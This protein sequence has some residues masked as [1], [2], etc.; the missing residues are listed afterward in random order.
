MSTEL[1]RRA[2]A[3]RLCSN[4]QNSKGRDQDLKSLIQALE[5]QTLEIESLLKQ[6]SILSQALDPNGNLIPF[7]PRPFKTPSPSKMKV[8]DRR[9]C[10]K[11]PCL[12]EGQS[13]EER[14]KLAFEIHTRSQNHIFI[15]SDSLGKNWNGAVDGLDSCTVFLPEV[16]YLN[17][18][19]QNLLNMSLQSE[20]GPL[21]V[22]STR[23]TLQDLKHLKEID[24]RFLERLSQAHFRMQGPLN[25]Y[26]KM[27]FFK[28]FLESLV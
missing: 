22:G 13:F 10:I 23:S 9:F 3:L 21:I 2:K 7:K 19:Q 12:I 16:L 20:E 24:G 1:V 14:K 5:S 15:D 17:S 25:E 27:G 18:S 11:T 4:V 8:F 6:E 28:L 26:L